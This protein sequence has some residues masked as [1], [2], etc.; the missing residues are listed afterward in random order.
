MAL[1]SSCF[2]SSSSTAKPAP[3]PVATPAGAAAKCIFCAPNLVPDSPHFRIVHHDERFIAFHDRAPAAA[4]HLL[5]VPRRH[6]ESVRELSGEEGAELGES[7]PC[8]AL[9]R[10]ER[11]A[12]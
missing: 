1:F 3:A 8:H 4:V 5:A 12:D 7:L 11:R 6:V 9:M 2:P 10:C